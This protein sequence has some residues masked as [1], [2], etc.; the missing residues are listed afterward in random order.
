MAVTTTTKDLGGRF[1]PFI[2]YPDPTQQRTSAPRGELTFTNVGDTVIT[3]GGAG[4]EQDLTVICRLPIGFA[5]ALSQVNISVSAAGNTWDPIMIG[6]QTNSDS[7]RTYNQFFEGVSAGNALTAQAGEVKV[8]KF[9][10]LPK[11]LIAQAIPDSSQGERPFALFEV[12]NATQDAAVGTTNIYIRY[13]VYD[14]EQW[15]HFAAN[16]AIQTR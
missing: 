5:Y 16:E 6:L 3:A 10:D 13:F 4:N 9:D 2:G 1:Q 12:Q 14:I 11:Q 8:Y 7:N 15:H